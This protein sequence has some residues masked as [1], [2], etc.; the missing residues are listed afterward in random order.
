MNLQS[1]AAKRKSRLTGLKAFA[2]KNCKTINVVIETPKGKRNKFRF[3]KGL[4]LFKL[5]KVLPAGSAFPYDF[6][7]I[8][9]TRAEDSDPLDVLL[10]MDESAYPGC[11]VEARLIGVLEAEQTE[12]GKTTR[13]D[14]LIAVAKESHSHSNIA[15]LRDLSHE[16]LKELEHFFKSYN[17]IAGKAFRVLAARGPKRAME[18]LQRHLE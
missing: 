8:P 10:L 12:E 7:F 6:G 16:L 9:G 1:V 2:A 5:R 13:N 18:T 11:I 4:G 17:E 14:R 3:D 15:S